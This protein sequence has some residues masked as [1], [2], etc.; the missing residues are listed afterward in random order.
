MITGGLVTVYVTDMERAIEFY[1]ETLGLELAYRGGP[2]WTVVRAPDG[3]GVGLHQT[4]EGAEAG[5]NGSTTLG[6][7]VRGDLAG[8]VEELRSRGVHFVTDLTEDTAVP[9]AYFEDP[10]GNVMYVVEERGGHG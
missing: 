8:V 1:T 5:E 9:L 3:F 7:R 4:M 6:F 2:S 10:D